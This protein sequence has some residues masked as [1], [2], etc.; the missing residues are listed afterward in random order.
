MAKTSRYTLG[1]KIDSLLVETAE[2]LFLAAHVQKEQKLVFLQ[3]AASKLDLLKF[4]LQVSWEIRAIDN[5]KYAA[6]SE[7]TQEIG[8]MLGGWTRQMTPRETQPLHEKGL[9]TTR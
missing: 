8:R 7:R 9:S 1:E 5:K 2:A 4:F 6:L 3:R